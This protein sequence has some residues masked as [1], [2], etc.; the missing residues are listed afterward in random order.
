MRKFIIITVMLFLS[1]AVFAQQKTVTGKVISKSTKEPLQGV[2]V[3]GKNKS[4]VTDTSGRFT[5]QVAPG[6]VLNLSYVG[7]N[8]IT[9][10]ITNSSQDLNIEMIEGTGDLNQVIV[11]GYKSERKVDLTGA[12]S[13]VNLSNVKNV[14]TTSPMLALQGQVPGLYIQT[15]GSPTG[16]NG[17]PPT[18]LV[19]G[20]NTLGNTNPLYIIDGVPTTRY[21]DFANLN[22]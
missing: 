12:V 21:E 15:D 3:Q 13:V 9:V 10:P 2:T 22:T 1:I 19:R 6:D 16:G 5:I 18:I 7:M 14:P 11:T 20:V 17:G 4:V 8:A